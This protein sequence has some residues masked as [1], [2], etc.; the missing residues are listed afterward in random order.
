MQ[1]QTLPQ[2][3]F[4]VLKWA[5]TADG[6][7]ARSDYSSRWISCD[8]SRELVHI[9]RSELSAVLVGARTAVVDAPALTARNP[10]GLLLPETTQPLRVVILPRGTLPSESPLLNDS[11]RTLIIAP[12]ESREVLTSLP[13]HILLETIDFSHSIATQTLSL[14][15]TMHVNSVLVEGGTRTLELFIRSNLWDEARVFKSPTRFHSG[16]AAPVITGVIKSESS[17]GIDTLMVLVPKGSI[18]E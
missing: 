13:S 12:H 15:H 2:R 8:A 6:F 7:I 18:H 1:S 10:S 14:L 11:A 4:V 3:P 17:F 5:Q 9:W 16:I